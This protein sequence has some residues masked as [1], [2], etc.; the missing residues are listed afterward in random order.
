MIGKFGFNALKRFQKINNE[1]GLTSAF[2]NNVFSDDCARPNINMEDF[3]WLYSKYSKK[4]KQ[5]I[6]WIY[7]SILFVF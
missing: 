4:K 2:I 6:Q 5:R 1:E 3:T 7:G